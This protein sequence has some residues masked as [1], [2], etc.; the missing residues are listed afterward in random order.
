MLLEEGR[1]LGWVMLAVG[2]A[3]CEET[4]LGRERERERLGD[5]SAAAP[6]SVSPSAP[7]KALTE[8]EKERW[9]SGKVER[10]RG[11]ARL[12]AP[13]GEVGRENRSGQGDSERRRGFGGS[14]GTL[15]L[16]R[17]WGNRK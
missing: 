2:G 6:A 10:G 8:L 14:V 1:C 4:K 15:G 11:G 17:V 7:R 3:V 5:A 16:S 9:K 13:L 12:G